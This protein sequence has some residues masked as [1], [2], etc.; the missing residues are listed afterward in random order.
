MLLSAIGC[1]FSALLILWLGAAGGFLGGV[2]PFTGL[3][4]VVLDA[5]RAEFNFIPFSKFPL[6]EGTGEAGTESKGTSFRASRRLCRYI[7]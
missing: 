4:P 3:G 6:E 2:A 5:G 7:S 1:D